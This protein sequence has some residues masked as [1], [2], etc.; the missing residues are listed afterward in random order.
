MDDQYKRVRFMYLYE[1][2]KTPSSGLIFIKWKI[3]ILDTLLIENYVRYKLFISR[4]LNTQLGIGVAEID[5]VSKKSLWFHY[6]LKISYT[7]I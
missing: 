4:A 7:Q 2:F 1:Y 6:K 5:Y 3:I